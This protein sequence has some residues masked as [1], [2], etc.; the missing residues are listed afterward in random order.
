VGAKSTALKVSRQA[1]PARP[2]G[3][4]W[5]DSTRLRDNTFCPVEGG[6][7]YWRSIGSFISYLAVNTY[8]LGLKKLVNNV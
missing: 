1:M 5:L 7:I 8:H 3:E 4:G 6:T 2:S